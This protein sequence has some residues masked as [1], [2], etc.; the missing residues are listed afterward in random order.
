MISKSYERL[1]VK[2]TLTTWLYVANG[3]GV[4]EKAR[5]MGELALVAVEEN[6][7]GIRTRGMRNWRRIETAMAMVSFYFLSPIAKIEALSFEPL[8]IVE[9]C[10]RC[11]EEHSEIGAAGP[12][13]RAV[14]YLQPGETALSPTTHKTTDIKE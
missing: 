8:G 12:W 5:D 3:V 11:S 7:I 4:D 6:E 10:W 2:F 1:F 13:S 9:L 14:D